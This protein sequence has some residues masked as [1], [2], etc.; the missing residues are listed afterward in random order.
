MKRLFCFV[1]MILVLCLFTSS[2]AEDTISNSEASISLKYIDVPSGI[3]PRLLNVTLYVSEDEIWYGG[4]AAPSGSW[5][6][7]TNT[8]ADILSEREFPDAP[9]NYPVVHCISKIDNTLMLGFID[10]ENQRGTVGILSLTNDRIR[11]TSI[12]SNVKVMKIVSTANG[13]LV[14][15]VIYNTDQNT[16]TLYFALIDN[17]GRTIFSKKVTTVDMTIDRYALASS[18][19]CSSNDQ[20]YV[21]AKTWEATRPFAGCELYCFDQQGTLE[22]QTKLPENVVIQEL[23]AADGNIYALGASGDISTEGLLINKKAT[24]LCYSE[25]GSE[26]WHKSC[27]ILSRF[28]NGT[29]AEGACLATN[30]E[31]GI[32]YVYTTHSDGSL[33]NSIQF[34]CGA[35]FYPQGIYRSIKGSTILLVMTEEQLFFCDIEY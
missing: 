1:M 32:C 29:S 23:S 19:C 22:W 4:T 10:A 12:D 27:N 13:L 21:L 8:N 5:L 25:Q 20:Y 9:G 34:D 6:I 30:V 2:I 15:G 16:S 3:N 33:Q 24:I 26:K 7:Q 31:A 11:Y 28:T 35:Q 18:L 17:N 14:I